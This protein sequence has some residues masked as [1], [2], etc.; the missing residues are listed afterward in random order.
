MFFAVIMAELDRDLMPLNDI[1]DEL[2]SMKLM[3]MKSV[4]TSKALVNS[5]RVFSFFNEVLALKI[6]DTQVRSVR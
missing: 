3:G 2:T 6:K 1:H 4:H 5:F